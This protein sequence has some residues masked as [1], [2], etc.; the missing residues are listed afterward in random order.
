MY[1]LW[2]QQKIGIPKHEIGIKDTNYIPIHPNALTNYN[3]LKIPSDSSITAY[4]KSSKCIDK[5]RSNWHL[6]MSSHFQIGINDTNLKKNDFNQ[7]HRN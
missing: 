7:I 6:I 1:F 5:L 2:L 3:S 4:T